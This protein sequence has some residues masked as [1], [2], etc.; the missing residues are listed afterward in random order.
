[1]EQNLVFRWVKGGDVRQLY[2][3]LAAAGLGLAGAGTSP[4]S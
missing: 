1:M 2:A 3:R 4:T